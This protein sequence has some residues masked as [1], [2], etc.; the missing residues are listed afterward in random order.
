MVVTAAEA[1]AQALAEAGTPG[2]GTPSDA[3]V[4]CC[5]SGDGEQHGGSRS[6]WGAIQAWACITCRPHLDFCLPG[7]DIL[8]QQLSH[9]YRCQ[10]TVQK[11]G[12]RTWSPFS[13]RSPR[14]TTPCRSP[15]PGTP[16]PCAR[17]SSTAPARPA[18][19]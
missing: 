15:R 5:P 9:Y 3:V 1:K 7:K 10:Q 11:G 19:P 8:I 16:T 14:R 2:T 18:T 17:R 6:S 12:Q 13:S 4:V